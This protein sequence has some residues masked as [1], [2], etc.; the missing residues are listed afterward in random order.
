VIAAE[1][2]M[3]MHRVIAGIDVEDD[4]FGPLATGADK[5]V[6]QVVVEDLDAAGLGGAD[7]LQERSFFQGQLG[8]SAGVGV[9]EACQGRAAGQGVVGIG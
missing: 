3:A 8:L 1:R 9:L 5:Q 2:L 7:F 6:D 4:L